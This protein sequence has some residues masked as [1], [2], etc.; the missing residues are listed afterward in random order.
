MSRTKSNKF[1]VI[2]SF[3]TLTSEFQFVDADNP[4]DDFKLFSKRIKGVEYSV[5]HFENYFY[6][7]TNRDNAKNYKLM[8]ALSLLLQIGYKRVTDRL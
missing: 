6:I 8:K 3:S 5:N 7:I 4:D 1:V 2:S